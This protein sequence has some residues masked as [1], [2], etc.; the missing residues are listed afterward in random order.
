ME[1]IQST[2]FQNFPELIFG[3]STKI[4][5][6][7]KTPFYFN[8]SFSVGDD[9]EIVK[10]NR[11]VFFNSLGLEH[12][13]IAIQK[14]THSDIIK[15]V[16]KPGSVG[17]SDS[18]ITKYPGIGLAVSTADCTPIFI[19]DKEN[20]VIA[21]VHSG[22]KGTQKRILKKTLN[23]LSHHFNSRTE[24]IYVYVGPSISQK[25][26]EIGKEV[27]VLFDQKYLKLENGKIYLDVL[28]VNV[29]MLLEF[30]IPKEQIEISHL[31]TFEEK[32]LL[33]SFRRDG[34]LSGRSLGVIALMDRNG[35]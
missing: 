17:E 3:L 18:I 31:C 13:Q 27:A 34:K 35:E 33:H 29:D 10:E 20:K 32:D 7:R 24:N 28:G 25:N 6:N 12:E 30:G 9:K 4:G 2:L 14:Q 5:L 11:S 23:N 16:E 15:F 22:W 19:Y 26:Y 8:L 1:I 21:A